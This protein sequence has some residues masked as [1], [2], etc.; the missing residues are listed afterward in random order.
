MKRCSLCQQTYADE[1]MRFCRADGAALEL[2][3][4]A[5]TAIF[6]SSA[7]TPRSPAIEFDTKVLS[8]SS[9]PLSR[10][11]TT[12]DLKPETH[13]AKSGDINV[14]YQVLGAPQWQLNL[15]GC[16]SSI[17]SSERRMFVGVQEGTL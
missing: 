10:S 17:G 14:A 8:E 7:V 1:T 2:V 11:R 4:D 12:A 5:P 3:E 6:A 15:K 13:Y 16:I 9:Q